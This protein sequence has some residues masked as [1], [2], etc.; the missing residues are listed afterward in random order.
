MLVDAEVEAEEA[1][2]DDEDE[3]AAAVCGLDTSRSPMELLTADAQSAAIA[4]S[5]GAGLLIG[6]VDKIFLR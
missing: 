5:S 6:C 4:A 2:D 3:D 1:G